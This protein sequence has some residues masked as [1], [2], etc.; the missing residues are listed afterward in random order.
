LAKLKKDRE[1]FMGLRQQQL[2]NNLAGEQNIQRLIGIIAYLD[3]EI[4]KLEKP[5][6]DKDGKRSS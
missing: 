3:E 1:R 2:Q 5:K 6:E 4:Q